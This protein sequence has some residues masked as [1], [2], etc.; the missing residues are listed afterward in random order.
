MIWMPVKI[1]SL[2]KNSI[3]PLPLFQAKGGINRIA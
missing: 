3:A 2:S 1:E